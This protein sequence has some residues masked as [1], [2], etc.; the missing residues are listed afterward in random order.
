[1]Q[2]A[3]YTDLKQVW[4]GLKIRYLGVSQVRTGRLETLE[5]EFECLRM[6]EGETVDDFATKL[7]GLAEKETIL[8]YELEDVELVKRLL[9]SMPRL[10]LQIMAPIEQC[11]ELD[12]MLFDEAL[13][14]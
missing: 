2:M 9:D 13:E 5:R 4:D 1:M 8:G 14:G 12:S 7:T 6:K 11:F 3:S 10:F